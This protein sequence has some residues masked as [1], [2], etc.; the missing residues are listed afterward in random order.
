MPEVPTTTTVF[1]SH[2]DP[3]ECVAVNLL[4]LLIDG[5]VIELKRLVSLTSHH[6]FSPII[7]D[8]DD[9]IVSA[10]SRGGGRVSVRQAVRFCMSSR[11]FRR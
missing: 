4:L 5:H 3:L 1:E 9:T 6:F 7:Y 8:V 11:C 2:A 10:G